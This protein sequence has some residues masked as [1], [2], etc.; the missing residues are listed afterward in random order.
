[1]GNPVKA[2]TTQPTQNNPQNSTTMRPTTEQQAIDR[3]C[4]LRNW[5][6][7]YQIAAQRHGTTAPAPHTR[8]NPQYIVIVTTTNGEEMVEPT[9][10]E[11]TRCTVRWWIK[12]PQTRTIYVKA[13]ATTH[14][15]HAGD[16]THARGWETL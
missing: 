2:H 9:T 10:L 11:R 5:Q 13:G 16:E 3:Q 4:D 14:K 6:R 12:Q 7:Y 15:F 1:M 8:P